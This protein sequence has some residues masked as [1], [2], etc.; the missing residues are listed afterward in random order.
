MHE[1]KYRL[2]HRPLFLYQTLLAARLLFQ[3]STLTESLEQAN[4][5]PNNSYKTKKNC[6]G[7]YTEVINPFYLMPSSGGKKRF[8]QKQ[9]NKTA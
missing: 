7:F 9:S 3:S 4:P 6:T 8:Y 5:N 1:V 2:S